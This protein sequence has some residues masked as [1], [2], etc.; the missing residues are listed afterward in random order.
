[1]T[2][3]KEKE[4]REERGSL[5][6]ELQGIVDQAEEDGW[7]EELLEQHEQKCNEIEK[8]QREINAIKRHNDLGAGDDVVDV[9]DM[10][11]PG[12]TDVEVNGHRAEGEDGVY[13]HTEKIFRALISKDSELPNKNE[14]IKEAQK[15]MFTAGHYPEFKANVEAFS[16]LTDKDGAIFLPTTISDRIMEIEREYG[17]FPENSLRIPL[18]VGGGRQI[19]P[20]LL[21][22]ITFHA[23]NQGNEAKASR[24]TFK[25]LT[26]E[27]LKWMGFVPWTNEVSAAAGERLV[28]LIMRKIGEGS[29]RT[30]DDAAINADGT[31]TYHNLK[32]LITRSDDSD[33]AEVRKS[34]A[35]TGNADFDSI[36]DD[37]F[38]DATLD[39][40]PSIRD[41]GIFVLHTDWK[42]RLRKIKDDNGRPLYLTGGAISLENGNWS[43]SG[44]PV[45]FTEKAPNT[46][47]A[48]EDYGIFYVPEYFAFGDVGMFSTEEL[49]EATIKDENDNDIRLAS[50]DM[51]A[52]RM[53]EF[54][55]FELSELT[56]SSGGN[57]LGAFTVLETAAS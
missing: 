49:T 57:D 38:V 35:A 29:A 26:L 30:K 13:H 44:H 50:Q 1:M 18:T 21:G 4:K 9:N 16:T 17:V 54:F 22:E 5:Y 33:F 36:D 6:E 52:L 11:T 53:K 25:G 55:D 12:D 48:S 24:F 27:E 45:R 19:V 14:V 31:S 28:E 32:G 2:T 23:T 42:V 3:V 7:T 39:V 43:I 34:T 51:R 40:A 37:D 46:D 10:L 47:G 20:N 56:I 41:R 15:T 8:L